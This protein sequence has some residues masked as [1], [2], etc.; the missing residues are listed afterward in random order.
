M[1]DGTGQHDQ[2]DDR[3]GNPPWRLHIEECPVQGK[4]CHPQDQVQP[5]Y[6]LTAVVLAQDEVI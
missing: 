3:E 2:Y 5:A 6:A 1:D 4:P